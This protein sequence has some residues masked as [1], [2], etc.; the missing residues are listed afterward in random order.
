MVKSWLESEC[1]RMVELLREVIRTTL[2]RPF[3]YEG[4]KILG[5]EFK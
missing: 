2:T 3:V 1:A 5:D 4:F